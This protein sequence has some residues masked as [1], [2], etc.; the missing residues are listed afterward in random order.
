MGWPP[1][2]PLTAGGTLEHRPV[3]QATPVPTSIRGSEQAAS[4]SGQERALWHRRTRAGSARGRAGPAVQALGGP[5]A[6]ATS[7][8]MC[9]SPRSPVHARVPTGLECPLLRARPVRSV[10][11]Q[12][13]I[14]SMPLPLGNFTAGCVSGQGREL[15]LRHA[16]VTPDARSW[17]PAR[18]SLTA[19]RSDM[20]ASRAEGE[21]A[22]K[23]PGE[24][25]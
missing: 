17:C 25:C 12:E 19:A 10:P 20:A 1:P 22:L 16:V 24:G 23:K 5:Q 9:P 13:V 8:S 18:I 15:S 3:L 2:W 21:L 4:A 11:A 14:P 6:S 7:S